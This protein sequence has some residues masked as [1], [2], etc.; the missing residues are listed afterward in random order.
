MSSIPRE[1]SLFYSGTITLQNKTRRPSQTENTCD[2]LFGRCQTAGTLE[3]QGYW[4]LGPQSLRRGQTARRTI[5]DLGRCSTR[6]CTRTQQ[7]MSTLWSVEVVDSGC[8][9]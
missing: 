1:H 4:L 5:F 2:A 8:I 7:V 3:Q 6:Q 9:R